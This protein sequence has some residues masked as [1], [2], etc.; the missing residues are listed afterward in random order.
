MFEARS[1][2]KLDEQVLYSHRLILLF[3]NI[4]VSR[5]IL[6]RYIYISEK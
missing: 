3:S 4:D 5:H 1:S 6:V 2:I